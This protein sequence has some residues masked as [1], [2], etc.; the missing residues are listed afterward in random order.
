MT[1]TKQTEWRLRYRYVL[2]IPDA[3]S[4][5]HRVRIQNEIDAFWTYCPTIMGDEQRG[6]QW[7]IEAYDGFKEAFNEE[8]HYDWEVTKSADPVDPEWLIQMA[9][10]NE[11]HK[12]AT[13]HP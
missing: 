5:Y 12:L 4:N 11:A 9:R 13:P 10:V 3:N 2:R 6:T 1:D 8:S 7:V